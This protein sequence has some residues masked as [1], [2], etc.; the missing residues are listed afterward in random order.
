V[1]QIVKEPEMW[2]TDAFDVRGDIT[3]WLDVVSF[4]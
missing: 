3:R 1:E 4:T 2:E